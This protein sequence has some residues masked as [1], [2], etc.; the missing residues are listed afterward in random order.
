MAADRITPQPV[1][2]E[3]RAYGESYD[4]SGNISNWREIEL[5]LKRDGTSG[6]FHQMSAGLEFV[7]DAREIVKGIFDAHRYS[8]AADVYVYIRRDDW[9]YRPDRYHAP[10]VFNLDFTTYS[11]SDTKIEIGTKRASLYDC[12]K[13]KGRVVYD[14]PVSEMR[15]QKRWRF[16]RIEL[17]NKIIFRVTSE[18]SRVVNIADLNS[19]TLGVAYEKTEVGVQDVIYQQPIPYGEFPV[20]DSEGRDKSSYF[21]WLSEDSDAKWIECDIDITGTIRRSITDF[22]STFALV[23]ES[24]DGESAFDI[25]TYTPPLVGNS[26]LVPVEWKGRT[27]FL[28]NKGGWGCYLLFRSRSMGYSLY[29]ID[30]DGTAT[31]RYDA[32]YRPVDVDVFSPRTLLGTLVDKMTGTQGVYSAD[33]AE[34]NGNSQDLIMMSAAESIRGIEPNDESEGAKVHTSY[35]SFMKWM[36]TFGYEEH[37]T[38]NVLAFRKRAMGFRADLTALELGADECADLREYV[39]D[40]YLYSGVRTGYQKKDIEN[41]NVR[42]EFNGT[43]DYSTDLSLS[44]KILEL[45]SPYRA[46]CYGIEFL[47]HEREKETTDNKADKDV[48]LVCVREGS[49]V[50]ET[51]KSVFSGNVPVNIANGAINDTMFNGKLHPFNLLKLNAGL[52]GVSVE[53]LEFTASDSNAEIIIDGQAINGDYDIPEGAGLFEPVMYDIASRNVRM[54]PEGDSVNGLVR[55]AYKGEIYAGFIEEITKNPAWEAETVWKLY[56]KKD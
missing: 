47:A 51:V 48:F 5:T 12:L 49:D 19:V 6:V 34:F 29:N 43:H 1:K 40:D 4:V 16:D 44:E 38:G 15:E 9:P 10:Q 2:F 26:D 23:L 33:I 30:I 31:V 3:L 21:M 42:F 28:I 8:S 20:P 45:I 52:I 36:N 46:D 24:L 13:A 11:R 54:L 41:A 32:R 37:I 22:D 17:E 53:R 39:N 25:M 50:Y 7:L 55:F 35:E 27:K 18:G 56:R 14:I